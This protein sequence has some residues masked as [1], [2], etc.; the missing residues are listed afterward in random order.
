MFPHYSPRPPPP[1]TIILLWT[2]TLLMSK[3]DLL[4]SPSIGLPASS[5]SVKCMFSAEGAFLGIALVQVGNE[6]DA[7]RIRREYS[8]Q[9]IDGSGSLLQ[10]PP[11][12]LSISRLCLHLLSFSLSL[13]A[14]VS[15]DVYVRVV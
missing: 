4:L 8:G 5:T 10:T 6:V 1:S 15:L 9:I 3:Q 11:S 13:S 7:E 2:G 14:R 12:P